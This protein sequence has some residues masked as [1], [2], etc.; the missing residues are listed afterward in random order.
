[1]CHITNVILFFYDVSSCT[2]VIVCTL[3]K[4]VKEKVPESWFKI[5]H[6]FYVLCHFS[7]Q[8][9]NSKY[10]YRNL[11]KIV[12]ILVVVLELYVQY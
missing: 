7:A 2:S 1:M 9:E 4:K 12:V 3:V 8:N 6:V 10:R 11:D 5:C